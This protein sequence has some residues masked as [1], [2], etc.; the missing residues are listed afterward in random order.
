MANRL[1][2]IGIVAVLIVFGFASYCGL[3]HLLRRV[4]RRNVRDLMRHNAGQFRFIV[5]SQNQ[6]GVDVEEPAGES[7]C[8]DFIGF[9]DLDRENGT[10]VS[11]FRTRFCPTRLTYSLIVGSTFSST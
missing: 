2:T 10:F 6:A 5:R 8:I 3:R 11:E 4:P 7:K 1:S 9:N